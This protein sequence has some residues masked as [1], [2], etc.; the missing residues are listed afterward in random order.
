MISKYG[1]SPKVKNLIGHLNIINFIFLLVV[2][3][4]PPSSFFLFFWKHFY[5]FRYCDLTMLI[6]LSSATA[7]QIQRLIINETEDLAVTQNEQS[8]Q[9]R[10]EAAV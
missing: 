4:P 10:R 6:F 7:L 3:F 8:S 1:L 2:F 5:S 9:G